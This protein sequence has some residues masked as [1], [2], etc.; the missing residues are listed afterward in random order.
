VIERLKPHEK[1]N[2][3]AILFCLGF[4]LC[5]QN[6]ENP[7]SDGFVKGRDFL[8]RAVQANPKHVEALLA[9]AEAWR[10]SDEDRAREK[11]LQAFGVAP[12]DPRAL[13]AYVRLKVADTRELSFVPLIRSS[14]ENAISRCR[15]QVA[16]GLNLPWALYSIGE[17][18]LLLGRPYESLAAY[19]QAVQRSDSEFMIDAA[20]ETV[21]RLRVLREREA[22]W[23]GHLDWVRRFLLLAKGAKFHGGALDSRLK[24][25]A[26]KGLAITGPVVILA[27]GCDLN[28]Q[29]RMAGYGRLLEE[30]F[31]DFRGTI[32]SGGT[33]AG[34][35]GLVGDLM[36]AYPGQLHALGYVPGLMPADVDIDRRYTK[37]LKTDGNDF[38]ALEPLQN[39][40]DLL[41]AG[42]APSDVKLLGIN[43]G[44]IAAFEYRLAAALGA[45]VG[46]L[47]G[48]GREADALIQTGELGSR[49][50]ALPDDLHTVRLFVRQ[51]MPSPL[52]PEERERL[53][54]AIHRRY[55]VNAREQ[56]EPPDP[57]RKDWPELPDHLKESNRKQADHHQAL[58]R[59]VGMTTERVA[60]GEIELIEFRP[61]E[62]EVMAEIEHA[63]F[64]VER[65]L[66]GWTLGPRDPEKKKSPYLV[67]WA[68]LPEAV[69]EWDRQAVRAVPE[70]LKQI[71]LKVRRLAADTPS[72]KAAVV[73]ARNDVGRD[74]REQR[75]GA[76][77][78]DQQP[79]P[80]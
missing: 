20:L 49:C 19:A 73:N 4:A 35:S 11:Y 13:A 44:E 2:D 65:L 7:R 42:I 76:G 74:E 26:S 31:R 15:D 47:R 8:D 55:L 9:S 33:R 52:A 79:H 71:G 23:A 18:S 27:G 37:V 50:L 17:F 64:N 34:I 78:M 56:F 3:P 6:K 10:V 67:P 38:S 32:D 39:W 80:G 22:K 43:G 51:G 48:S 77:A 63:R 53:G 54:Q 57:S 59:A 62:V 61:E 24:D 1:S 75:P 40:I 12:S 46:L 21:D 60:E 72:E 30:A 58:L 16:V 45:Q 68:E 66:D 36:E 25:L 14:L 41:A 5:Q 69:K 70:I 29:T 28:V